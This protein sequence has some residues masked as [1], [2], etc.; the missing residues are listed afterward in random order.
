VPEEAW[1]LTGITSSGIVPVL[2]KVFSS[3]AD[4]DELVELTS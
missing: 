1:E 2:E 4:V 3:L